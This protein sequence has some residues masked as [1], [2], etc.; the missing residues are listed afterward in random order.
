MIVSL[1][2]KQLEGISDE[3]NVAKSIFGLPDGEITA[4]ELRE[5]IEGLPGDYSVTLPMLG[6]HRV[7]DIC[8]LHQRPKFRG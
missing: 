7:I 6:G 3:S 4:A 2:R 8:P 1:I 5:M